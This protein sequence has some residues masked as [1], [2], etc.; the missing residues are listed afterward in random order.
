MIPVV[1]PLTLSLV[2]PTYNRAHL[3]IETIESA[4]AQTVSFF[5]IIV[6]DDGSTDNTDYLLSTYQE[7]IRFFRTENQGVQAA[8]NRGVAEARSTFVTLCDS[9]D[10]FLPDYVE[11]I[12]KHLASSEACNAIYCNFIIFDE[13]KDHSAKLSTAPNAFFA[14]SVCVDNV[15]VK[16]PDLYIKTLTYQPFF[17]TGLTIRKDFYAS[18]GGFNIAFN[19][20]GSEDWEFTLRVIEHTD[21]S[22]YKTPLVK[23]R[24][25]SSNDSFDHVR[26]NIGEAKV[27][28]YA[29]KKH[30]TA[31]SREA[32]IK[33]SIENR[34]L[35]A[36]DGAY[37]RGD[38]VLATDLESNLKGMRVTWRFFLKKM[39]LKLPCSLR[40]R[41]WLL[42]QR[43]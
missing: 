10:L 28:E 16:I 2:I 22:L 3:I 18:L 38:F 4:L 37:A 41:M 29:L 32:I 5:E 33:K 23:I 1:K 13:N 24:K 26:Q 6:V 40:N 12:T 17:P 7:K 21:V 31:K 8:R 43:S 39:I 19:G 30:K 9:D 25:H 36:F 35:L 14:D 27:L 15:Y 11:K 20:V 34:R 42:T